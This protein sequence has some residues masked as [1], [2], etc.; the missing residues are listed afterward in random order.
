M[1]KIFY[2][3]ILMVSS[4]FVFNNNVK[5]DTFT[6]IVNENDFNY[7]N[8]D[9]YTVRELASSY[10]EKYNYDYIIFYDKTYNRFQVYYI[11]NGTYTIETTTYRGFILPIIKISSDKVEL[12][13]FSVSTLVYNT[14]YNSASIWFDNKEY[15]NIFS[16]HAFLDSNIK[17][18]ISTTEHIHNIT[19]NEFTYS[20]TGDNF[21][22]SLYEYKTIMENPPVVEPE[23][24]IRNESLDSFYA[25]VLEKIELFA[26]YFITNTTLLFIIGIIILIFIIELIFRR[27][28]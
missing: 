1:R 12:Y 10:S 26:N 24:P 28:L 5:A 17:V 16:Y 23:E 20:I 14:S 13:N 27:Y 15:E 21:F 6:Y 9:F 3:F 2:I 4:F 18:S 22:P 25:L 7:L 19:Y 8:D 11:T